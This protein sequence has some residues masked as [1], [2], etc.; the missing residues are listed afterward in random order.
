MRLAFLAAILTGLVLITVQLATGEP[1]ASNAAGRL[2]EL[3]SPVMTKSSLR[4]LRTGLTKAEAVADALTSVGL[5]RLAVL[6]RQTGAQFRSYLK[7]YDPAVSAGLAMLPAT[8]R[9]TEKIIT[10][11]ERRRRQYE[12][13]ASLPGLGLTL[14]SAVWSTVVLGLLLVIAGLIGFI[15]PWRRLVLIIGAVGVALVVSQ[16][17]L[18]NLG[19]ASDTDALL[20]S[21]RPFSVQ[22]VAARR[23]ALRTVENVFNGFQEEVIPQVAASAKLTPGAVTAELASVSPELSAASL[24]QVRTVIGQYAP[25]VVASAVF[26]KLLVRADALSAQAGIWLLIGGGFVLLL[27]S[28]IGLVTV[29][30]S[31]VAP[32]RS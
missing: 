32:I 3:T 15:R 8:R 2:I 29:S 28:A 21:L 1:R 12:S 20:N 9:L 5:P 26:Q 31:R 23:A 11:L 16:L 19:K 13:A 7:T 25:L 10:N 24:S 14:N 27:A 30:R 6:A 18:G 22:R 17:A 4:S